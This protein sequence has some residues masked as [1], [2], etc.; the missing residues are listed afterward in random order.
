MWKRC[1]EWKKYPCKHL[2]QFLL[3]KAV[4]DDLDEPG[5]DQTGKEPVGELAALL[6]VAGGEVAQI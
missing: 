3:V 2:V 1:V 6:L 5:V 4:V